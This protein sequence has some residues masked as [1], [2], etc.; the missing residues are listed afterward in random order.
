MVNEACLQKK[1]YFMQNYKNYM[2]IKKRMPDY[3]Y[4][5]K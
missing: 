5:Q 1:M 3:F 2:Y 4:V